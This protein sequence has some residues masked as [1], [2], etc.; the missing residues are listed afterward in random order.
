MNWL[1]TIPKGFSL[2][3]LLRRS[4]SFLLPPFAVA[5][6]STTLLLLR[7]E[8]LV[9][10]K[11]IAMTLNQISSGIHLGVD[12]RLT[13]A[14]VEEISRKTW[15]MLRMG[16]NLRAF[17]DKGA[18]DP[19]LCRYTRQGVRFLRGTSLFEDLVKALLLAHNG[20]DARTLIAQ[21]VD[22][23][24]TPYP[25]NPTRHAFPSAE[26]ILNQTPAVQ[27]ILGLTL[28]G[29]LLA[30]AEMDVE[31][32]L[33]KRTDP[34]ALEALPGMDECALALVMLARGQYNYIPATRCAS[35][36]NGCEQRT[37]D[38]DPAPD[39]QQASLATWQPWG[40]LVFW[41]RICESRTA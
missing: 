17:V 26:Q 25:K 2:E 23:L 38:E 8:R 15:R 34:A 13:G 27:R 21:L 4:H 11:V 14:E 6:T 12:E 24:G 30:A 39:A 1:F 32:A 31:A 5:E 7:T 35:L 9:S 22:Q 33:T 20:A 18:A 37:G 3:G 10:G 40:G 28:G 29:Y 36:L 19:E 16:E 41:L